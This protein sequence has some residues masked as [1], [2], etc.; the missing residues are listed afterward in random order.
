VWNDAGMFVRAS[1]FTE[2]YQSFSGLFF[3]DG[4]TLD[5]VHLLPRIYC[6]PVDWT[7][8]ATA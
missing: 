5:L 8:T 7:A 4:E 3:A 6:N 2:D 1:Y